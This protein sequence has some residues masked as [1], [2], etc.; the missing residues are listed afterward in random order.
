MNTIIITLF[1]L[2]KVDKGKGGA[3]MEIV[4]G[5]TGATGKINFCR[6]LVL[7]VYKYQG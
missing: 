5:T 3:D 4:T 2:I 6:N 1:I 7:S